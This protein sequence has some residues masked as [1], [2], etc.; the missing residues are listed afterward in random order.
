MTRITSPFQLVA[1]GLGFPEGPVALPDGRIAFTDMRLQT[2][3]ELADSQPPSVLA[4]TDGSPN[5]AALGEDGLLYVA[6]NGGLAPHSSESVW[7]ATQQIE[8]CIQAYTL[9]GEP[10]EVDTGILP[11]RAPHRPNDLCF[12][13]DGYLYF[14]DPHN[15]EVL[16]SKTP[17]E[18]DYGG[19]RVLR[20][21]RRGATELIAEVPGFPNG[22]AVT[23]D[24]AELVVAQTIH[25]RLTVL[26]IRPGQRPRVA[27][28]C[29]LPPTVNPDGICFDTEGY[30]FV[31]G[32]AGDNLAV[33]DPG[34]QVCE[35]VGLPDGSC[36]TNVCL[37]EGRLWL[38]LGLAGQV[39]YVETPSSPHP[40]ETG[41]RSR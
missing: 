31:A 17:D 11:G 32:S 12:G 6:N 14:T 34:R 7:F 41:H 8:G 16:Q 26:P 36:P 5:G 35:L 23:P 28:Y 18:R 40:L 4:V 33:V 24:G 21:D 22:L 38:T 39:G 1:D 9:D 2:V 25:H 15:W 10:R 37:Q 13:S 3:F 30:L 20:T 29:E 27:V 19:G